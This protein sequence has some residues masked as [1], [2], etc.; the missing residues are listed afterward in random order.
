MKTDLGRPV[1]QFVDKEVSFMDFLIQPVEAAL[2]IFAVFN[3][4]PNQVS[5]CGCNPIAG[6][7]C[8]LEI[9]E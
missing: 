5:V 1:D 7:T 2:M 8:P 3:C 9:K 4:M 6:C